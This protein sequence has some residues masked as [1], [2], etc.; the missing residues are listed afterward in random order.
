MLARPHTFMN[1]AGQA[2]APLV[3]Y[4]ASGLDD[5]LVVQDDIDLP[6][7]KLRVVYDSGSGGNNGIR[8]IIRSVGDSAFWRLKCGLGRPPGKMDPAD[9]V[10]RRFASFERDTAAVMVQLAA[11][12]VERFVIEGGDAARQYAGELNPTG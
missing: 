4:Y 5:L 12:V 3:R 2:V 1:E 7:A 8:S 6:F 11:D 10:L 9:F